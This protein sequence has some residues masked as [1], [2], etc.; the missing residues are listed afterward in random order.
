MIAETNV[1]SP[2]LWTTDLFSK[3]LQTEF[4]KPYCS[5]ESVGDLE[6]VSLDNELERSKPSTHIGSSCSQSSASSECSEDL[7]MENNRHGDHDYNNPKFLNLFD[8]NIITE[9]ISL[10]ELSL[11]AE[12]DFVSCD[13]MQIA[14]NAG[15]LVTGISNSSISSLPRRQK[16]CKLADPLS[17]GKLWSSMS[18]LEQ[19]ETVGT[20]SQIISNE[21]GLREQLDVIRI[22]DP[23][24]AISATDTEF[25]IDLTALTD[26]KL[27]SVRE[28]VRN[29]QGKTNCNMCSTS[30]GYDHDNGEWSEDSSGKK[31]HHKK[32]VKSNKRGQKKEEKAIK[33]RQ[34]KEHRQ[35]MKEKR[36]GL[37]VKEEV[38]SIS[39]NLHIDDDN[40]DIDI[41]E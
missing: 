22:I 16:K 18:Q 6:F 8:D 29:V 3:E 15:T 28:Y 41:L 35:L 34:K 9:P 10:Y 36:S 25:I 13:T 2:S 12:E 31:H 4:F 27:Q 21:L 23:T 26:E 7:C 5:T 24:A 14:S 39:T 1:L 20:L 37:F 32:E 11:G 30:P 33:Q 38:L 19:I 17:H 40:M